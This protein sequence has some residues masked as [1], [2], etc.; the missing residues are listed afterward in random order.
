[1][2]KT[3]CIHCGDNCGKYP[4]IWN[5][6]NFCCDGCKTVYQIL[7][8]HKL[9]DYYNFESHP[10]IKVTSDNYHNK[11]SYLD[12]DDVKEKLYEFS[13]KNLKK[14]TLF[15]PGIHCS[16]CIW[17]LENLTKLNAG[18][19]HSL[20]HFVKKEVTIT[21]N[22]DEISL[23]QVVELLVSIH[24]IPNITLE[25]VEKR[26][27][28]KGNKQLLYKIGIA[29][30]AFGNTMLFSFPEYIPGSETIDFSYKSFFGILNL[31]LAIPVFFYC[32][33]DYIISAW[34]NIR[35]GI[36]NIDFPIAIG[37][38]A[39][40]AES[41]YEILTKIGS[42]YMDSLCG[43]VFFL[44]VG[45]WYQAK[46]YQALSFNRNY[47]S[48]FPVAV[49]KLNEGKEISVQLHD[50]AEGDIIRIRNQE[51]IPADSILISPYANIDYSFVTGESVPVNKV[52]GEFVYAGGKQIGSTIELLVKTS[53]Q[54]SRLTQ[55]WNQEQ[56]INSSRGNSSLTKLIDVIS[57][58][59]TLVVLIIG[60]VTA[61]VWFFV[62]SSMIIKAF[63]SV[64]IVACPCALALS[65][66]FTYS[67]VM[68]VFGNKGLYLK[69]NEVLERLYDIETI[70]FDK[71][72]TITQSDVHDIVFKSEITLSNLEMLEI[73]SLARHST[74]PLSQSVF[75]YLTQ[76][77]S[78]DNFEDAI[79]FNEISGKGIEGKVNGKLFKIGSAIFVTGIEYN[80]NEFETNVHVSIDNIYYGKFVLNTKLRNNLENILTKLKNKGY[81]L[82]LIS[83]DTIKDN[84]LLKKYFNNNL[85][86]N[87][88]PEDKL[89]YINSL[90]QTGKKVLMIGDGLNDAGA[91]MQS[92]VGISIADN[93]YHFS[94]ACDAILKAE[95]FDDLATFISFS[96]TTRKIIQASFVF[97]FAYNSVGLYYAVMGLLSPIVA[98]ILMPLSSITVVG[99]VTLI[100][101]I[102]ANKAL[103]GR[104]S[105]KV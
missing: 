29:G 99:F 48:Y 84:D 80:V 12:L 98:A 40:F 74:H 63:T 53:T 87:K 32:G 83:G 102:Q 96:K 47:R 33:S 92:D 8:K 75:K 46:T 45:K 104:S 71:T 86:F 18:I 13:E 95:S 65:L 43:L 69:N 64:L 55:L 100:S 23:R 19:T 93:I 50:L 90:Q 34:K 105:I 14:V 39:I 101:S 30:F 11:F 59:F 66:P 103:K 35:K 7:N 73:A 24:Y 3:I 49:T 68:R 58:R 67:N 15:I 28:Q 81:D 88:S 54:Q 31:L 70:V 57:K 62:D 72:G 9:Y 77:Y 94:P 85:H 4:I 79:D 82:H 52:K 10:G 44:L 1:M 41:A 51:L 27:N 97:S 42:G 21:F 37:L 20:V 56:G 76:N 16:S 22:S 5:E 60:F 78:F 26:K 91:L 36:L 38:I 89:N 6:K 61:V 2:E 17:L 25:S